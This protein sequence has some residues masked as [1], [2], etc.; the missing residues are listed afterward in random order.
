VAHLDGSSL[1]ASNGE[2][3]AISKVVLPASD[4]EPAEPIPDEPLSQEQSWWRRL[5]RRLFRS[6]K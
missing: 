3:P 2:A 4:L 6:R 5:V 1:T